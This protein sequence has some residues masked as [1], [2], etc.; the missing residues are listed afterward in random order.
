[1][2]AIP[3]GIRVTS[4]I[5]PSDSTDDYGTHDEQYGIGGYRSVSTLED[6]DTIPLK[7][8]KL[9]MLVNV[10]EEGKVYQ[11]KHSL[12]NNGWDIFIA[13][14]KDVSTM[15]FNISDMETAQ[16]LVMAYPHKGNIVGINLT[17]SIAETTL[18]FSIEK[19]PGNDY[20]NNSDNW[21]TICI[22]TVQ[23]GSKIPDEFEM[24]YTTVNE[25]DRFRINPILYNDS[26]NIS[27]NILIEKSI[28]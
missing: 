20:V 8:R 16:D 28:D 25:N 3:G 15:V 12:D 24:L 21:V 26:N 13:G 18:Q 11:L 4:F 10:L 14:S 5:A 22:I 6:R 9:G 2:A 7:R 23:P 1:M 19:L 17:S 27:I